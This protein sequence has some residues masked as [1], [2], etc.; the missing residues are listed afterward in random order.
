MPSLAVPRLNF[1][2]DYDRFVNMNRYWSY[3]LYRFFVLMG[4][5]GIGKTTGALIHAV[6]AWI[7]SGEEFVYLR[8]YK[9]ELMKAKGVLDP[10]IS[11]VSTV[12]VGKGG[13]EYRWGNRRIGFGCTLAMQSTFKSGVDFSKVS[14]IIFDEAILKPRG[15]LR[16]LKD[17]M[18]EFLEFVSTV[19]RLRTNYRVLILGNNMDIFN[20]YFEYFGAPRFE[21]EYGDRE[22]GIYFEKIKNKASLMEAQEKTPLYALTKGTAYGNYHYANEVLVPETACIEPKAVKGKMAFRLVYNGKTVNVYWHDVRPHFLFCEMRDRE[23][24]DD[25]AF[26]ISSEGKPN[27]FYAKAFRNGDVGRMML[28]KYGRKEISYESNECYAVVSLIMDELF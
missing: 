3:D 11:G 7:K 13:F 19:T 24:E 23:I 15:N 6:Q 17:E 16:Y 18:T 28:A 21:V 4:G 14:L 1:V 5:R 20:P 12:G 22:R 27:Y 9:S 26:V 8:R 10:L 25:M 2:P